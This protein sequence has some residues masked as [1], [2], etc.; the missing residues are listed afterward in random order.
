MP[1]QERDDLPSRRSPWILARM[2]PPVPPEATQAF[3]G[4]AELVYAGGTADQVLTAI[5]HAA[6]DVVPGCDHACISTLSAPRALST[7]AASDDVARL[8]DQLESEAGEGPC[9]DSILED[10]FQRDG[11]I[12]THS[13]W[14]RLAELTLARTPVRSMVGYR[15]VPEAGAPS[16]F[17]LFGDEPDA[18]TEAG[19][20]VGAV[21]A[22]FTSVALTAVEHR[23]EAENLRRGL[24][25]NREI[26]K[27]VGL[28][29]AAHSITDEEAFELLRHAS[30]RTNTRLADLARRVTESHQRPPGE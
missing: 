3:A 25:S 11:D 23:H 10:S 18:L 2:Q 24:Q 7:R 27:A 6:V 21:L 29:M 17:N 30:S 28:L 12:A 15:L 5:V 4:L 19:A 1:E 22:S 8:M 20:D 13:T 16:A 14:P 26:G 9:L